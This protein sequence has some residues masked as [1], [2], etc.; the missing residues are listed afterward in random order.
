MKE[1]P[2]LLQTSMLNAMPMPKE[3]ACTGFGETLEE[4]PQ[5][6]GGCPV[7]G[8]IHGQIG[9]GYENLVQWQASLPRQGA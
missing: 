3:L 4:F 2:E 8:S 7:S 5:R 6:G 9:W 1:P